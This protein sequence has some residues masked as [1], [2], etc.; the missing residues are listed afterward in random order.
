MHCPSRGLLS[1]G[2]SRDIDWWEMGEVEEGGAS[3]SDERG[4]VGRLTFGPEGQHP[5][6][7]CGGI[8]ARE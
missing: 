7:E 5:D 4:V 6:L 2:L 8:L 3:D 1:T